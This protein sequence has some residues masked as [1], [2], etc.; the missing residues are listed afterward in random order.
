LIGFFVSLKDLWL[1]DAGFLALPNGGWLKEISFR[2]NNSD[3]TCQLALMIPLISLAR[4]L[5]RSS[6]T[7]H[8]PCLSSSSSVS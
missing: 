1:S 2:E 5:Y 6:M 4:T 8:N 3:N 7:T